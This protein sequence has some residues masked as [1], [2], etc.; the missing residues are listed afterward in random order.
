[1]AE[2]DYV[3]RGV[4]GTVYLVVQY[5]APDGSNIG[6]SKV[7]VENIETGN[8]LFQQNQYKEYNA[9]E[10]KTIIVSETAPDNHDLSNDT[11]EMKLDIDQSDDNGEWRISF[12][13]TLK[14]DH[15][16][17]PKE[18]I[19]EEFDNQQLFPESCDI[20]INGNSL[21]TSIGN[22]TSFEHKE[23]ITGQL[24]VGQTNNI[25]VTSETT[26]HI[27]MWVEGDV[28]RDIEGRG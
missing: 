22:G 2:Q 25:E 12:G 1:M 6:R 9:D 8:I 21:G 19:I 15:I 23:D 27:Q 13:N 14:S 24:N 10:K 4:I 5:I 11:V 28:Y 7:T 26:G 20:K 16:H 18:G 17:R 3:S